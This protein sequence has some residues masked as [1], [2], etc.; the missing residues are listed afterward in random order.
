MGELSAE[1]DLRAEAPASG[2][3]GSKAVVSL[4]RLGAKR[5]K[6]PTRL[7]VRPG[8]SEPILRWWEPAAAL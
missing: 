7:A 4:Q 3:E 6:Q 2:A 8:R 5:Q 1:A